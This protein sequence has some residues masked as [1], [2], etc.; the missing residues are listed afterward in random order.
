MKKT[1]VEKKTRGFDSIRPVSAGTE[2]KNALQ[3]G[4]VICRMPAYCAGAAAT[5]LLPSI[6]AA[7]GMNRVGDVL[8]PLLIIL[9]AVLYIPAAAVPALIIRLLFKARRGKSGAEGPSFLRIYLGC[10]AG[11]ELGIGLSTFIGYCIAPAGGYSDF[12]YTLYPWLITGLSI[13]AGTAGGLLR[14]RNT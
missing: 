9:L 6:A 13:A 8:I 12:H 4:S 3:W 10:L 7:N 11:G 1:C 14:R 2:R 5:V